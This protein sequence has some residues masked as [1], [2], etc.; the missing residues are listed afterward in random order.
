MIKVIVTYK[1]DAII[2]MNVSG[3]AEFSEY[4]SDIVCAG[5]SSLVLSNLMYVEK[6]QIGVIE[7]LQEDNRVNVKVIESTNVLE[8]MLSAIVEGLELI[9]AEY[10]KYIKIKKVG[11]E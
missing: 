6:H 4:G 2:E 11:G 1:K 10:S 7:T 9:Q 5:V 3:H 8:H